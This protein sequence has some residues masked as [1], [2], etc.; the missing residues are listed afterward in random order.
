ME[1][2]ENFCLS[3]DELKE[4]FKDITEGENEE[5]GFIF[6]CY[7]H[8][9]IVEKIMKKHNLKVITES[10][11]DINDDKIAFCFRSGFTLC[12]RERWYFYRGKERKIDYE[13]ILELDR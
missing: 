4:I 2:I 9:K 11:F 10:I 12:N 8:Q 13:E 1:K 7:P 5:I 3:Y 6:A